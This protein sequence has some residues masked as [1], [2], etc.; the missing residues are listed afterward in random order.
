MKLSSDFGI[1]SGQWPGSDNFYRL[2][3]GG[4]GGEEEVV[5]WPPN[6]IKAGSKWDYF[7]F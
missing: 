6:L 2:S 1:D 5:S 7:S 4:G 3:S